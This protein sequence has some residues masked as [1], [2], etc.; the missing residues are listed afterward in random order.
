MALSHQATTT[1]T[2]TADRSSASFAHDAGSGSN[3][4]MLVTTKTLT[5]SGSISVSSITYNGVALTFIQGHSREYT[6]N[7]YLRIENWYLIAP[8][9]G[10]NTLAVTYSG[11]ARAD[12]I[13]VTTLNGGHQTTPVGVVNAADG[14]ST[15]PSVTLTTGTNNSWVM[16]GAHGRGGDLDPSTPGTGLTELTDGDTGASTSD[17]IA[18]TDGYETT[19]T[20]GSVTVDSTFTG[21]SDQWVAAAVEIKEAASGTEYTQSVSGTLTTSG[22]PA[23]QTGKPLSGTVSTAGNPAKTT[24]KLFSGTL[25]TDGGLLRQVGKLVSGVLTT[26]GNITKTVAKAVSGAISPDGNLAKQINKLLGGT[27]STSGIMSSIRLFVLAVGGALGLDGGLLKRTN[28]TTGGTL[29]TSGNITRVINKIL[30]GA[31]S[32]AGELATVLSG[33]ATPVLLTLKTRTRQLVLQTRTAVL[34]LRDRVRTLT[35]PDEWR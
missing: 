31:L 30:S 15:N 32:L 24:G 2:S 7:R 34:S 14:D 3:R 1:N 29:A 11:N 8:A 13:T 5:A 9:T 25:A 33:V 10:S 35:L 20:A 27:L 23:K 4:V 18:F 26:A 16:F 21:G 17:D 28:K 6:T 22:N 12:E 19:T